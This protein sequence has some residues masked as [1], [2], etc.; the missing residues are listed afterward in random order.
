MSP[1]TEPRQSQITNGEEVLFHK[2][3]TLKNFSPQQQKAF[4]SK[5]FDVPEVKKRQSI[6]V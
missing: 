1:K 6:N 2:V 3:T 5:K 4:F